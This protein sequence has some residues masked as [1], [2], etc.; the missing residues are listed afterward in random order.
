MERVMRR[1]SNFASSDSEERQDERC[2]GLHS[3]D[4]VEIVVWMCM[5]VHVEV[6]LHVCNPIES[7]RD[8]KAE[9]SLRRE[10]LFTEWLHFT[11][12]YIVHVCSMRSFNPAALMDMFNLANRSQNRYLGF[13]GFARCQLLRRSESRSS[14]RGQFVPL[15]A[16]LWKSKP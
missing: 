12:A 1:K 15:T 6:W 8:I 13:S 7:L 9:I 3:N 5:C 16:L 2:M 4:M 11:A 14:S 10:M